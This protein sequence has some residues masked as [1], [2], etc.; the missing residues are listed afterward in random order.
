MD[1][2][3]YDTRAPRGRFCKW[4]DCHGVLDWY[5]CGEGSVGICDAEDRG[6]D[7]HYCMSTHH[8]LLFALAQRLTS[9]HVGLLSPR[10][11]L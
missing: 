8:H 4:Y 3:L 9:F 11:G 1:C 10:N 2:H 7:C 6:E 5:Y